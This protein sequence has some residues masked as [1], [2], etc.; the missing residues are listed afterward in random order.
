MTQLYLMPNGKIATQNGKPVLMEQDDFTEC[1]CGDEFI[2]YTYQTNGMGVGGGYVDWIYN[3][4]HTAFENTPFEISKSVNS[5]IYKFNFESGLHCGDGLN[6]HHFQQGECLIK[7]SIARPLT[8]T[9]T[10][11]GLYNKSAGDYYV[12]FSPVRVIETGHGRGLG[13]LIGDIDIYKEGVLLSSMSGTG[14]SD[15]PSV[16]GTCENTASSFSWQDG[17]TNPRSITLEAGLY[18]IELKSFAP[19]KKDALYYDTTG[20]TPHKIYISSTSK[21]LLESGGWDY[22]HINDIQIISSTEY[23]MIDIDFSRPVPTEVPYV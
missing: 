7:L 10:G 18:D 23:D 1:C 5:F 14:I 11:S 17:S 4:D 6:N 3:D 13:F 21:E 16:I 9:F 15:D 22:D 8:L 19:S 20:V 2:S 12:A